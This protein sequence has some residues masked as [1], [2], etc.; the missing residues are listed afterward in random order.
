MIVGIPDMKREP[1]INVV[2]WRMDLNHGS[3]NNQ[4][5]KSYNLTWT[6]WNVTSINR[7]QQQYI[8]QVESQGLRTNRGGF[9]RAT[10][11]AN[12]IFARHAFGTPAY[13][14]EC[15]FSNIGIE[16]ADFVSITHPAMLDF[17]TGNIGV[18]N[19]LCEVIHRHPH[20]DR[21]TMELKVLDTRFMGLTTASTIGSA[22]I[23]TSD[24]F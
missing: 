15:A 8:T 1:V 6:F 19:V 22:V 4:S 24:I 23:G 14:F 20:Y 5:S 17:S 7:Y 11:L 3:T 12:R 21:G 16:L 2:K 18:Q 13:S 10:L 9:Q